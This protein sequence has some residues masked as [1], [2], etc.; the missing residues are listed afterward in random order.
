FVV[1]AA[2]V[3]IAAAAAILDQIWPWLLGFVVLGVLAGGAYLLWV[4]SET[5]AAAR[6]PE[7]VYTQPY[8][9][10]TAQYPYAF[11]TAQASGQ[12]AYPYPY[13]QPYAYPQP[14]V[15]APAIGAAAARPCVETVGRTEGNHVVLHQCRRGSRFV[16]GSRS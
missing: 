15:S 12:Y 2:M 5:P 7:P 10:H 4:W 13:A 8:G 11:H 1:W 3:V 9:F 14:V 16:A 6:T